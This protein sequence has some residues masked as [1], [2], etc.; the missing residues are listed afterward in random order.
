[1]PIHAPYALDLRHIL[2]YASQ[3]RHRLRRWSCE[4]GT[5]GWLGSA[6]PRIRYGAGSERVEGREQKGEGFPSVPLVPFD[7]LRTS[8]KRRLQVRYP[9]VTISCCTAVVTSG[10]D[11]DT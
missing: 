4:G 7:K 1:M 5:Q 10:P 9:I 11:S 2:T 8:G 3:E 6:H